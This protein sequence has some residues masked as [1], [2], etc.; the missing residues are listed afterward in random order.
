MSRRAFV[1]GFVAGFVIAALFGIGAAKMSAST[2]TLQ[3]ANQVVLTLRPGDG[4]FDEDVRG[5]ASFLSLRD[6]DL[7]DRVERAVH[8][9]AQRLQ[10]RLFSL[11][12]Y[13]AR[14]SVWYQT[15]PHCFWYLNKI[16]C[17]SSQ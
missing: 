6:P 3:D 10:D 11:T 16:I 14:V 2:P 13:K 4:N 5:G 12:G 8:F 17:L 9:D 15:N 7:L 1:A